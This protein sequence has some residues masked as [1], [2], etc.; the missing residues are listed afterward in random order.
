LFN[1]C[2]DADFT[3]FVGLSVYALSAC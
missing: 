3:Y 1:I 2:A